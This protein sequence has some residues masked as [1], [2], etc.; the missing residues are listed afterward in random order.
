MIQGCSSMRSF[1]QVRHRPWRLYRVIAALCQALGFN[2]A[3]VGGK[4]HLYTLHDAIRKV[5]EV[6]VCAWPILGDLRMLLGRHRDLCAGKICD[7][8]A[9]GKSE[10]V[11]P[12]HAPLPAN[13]GA[14]LP[15][16]Y[17]P[18]WINDFLT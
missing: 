14:K 16:C 2:S 15:L 1:P 6:H 5:S 7:L 8:A 4:E 9:P 13:G 11:G 17:I 18:N 12:G 3:P 10:R